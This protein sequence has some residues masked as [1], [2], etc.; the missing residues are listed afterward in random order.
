MWDRRGIS[1]FMKCR[2]KGEERLGGIPATTLDN[3]LKKTTPDDTGLIRPPAETCVGVHKDEVRS[4]GH[5]YF[6]SQFRV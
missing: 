4:I 1:F 6:Q 3:W 2:V 5:G